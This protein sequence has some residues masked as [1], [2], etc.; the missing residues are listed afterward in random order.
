MQRT[1][2]VNT[3]EL[4]S[5][6]VV[7]FKGMKFYVPNWQKKGWRTVTGGRV[8]NEKE[9]RELL[10]VSE[11]ILVTYVSITSHMQTCCSSCWN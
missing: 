11:G 3:A 8:K 9:L 10:A 7:V 6:S 1:S 4:Y 5:G 2:D